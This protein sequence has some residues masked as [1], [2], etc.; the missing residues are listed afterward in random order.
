MPY[1][2]LDHTRQVV[3]HIAT[4]GNFLNLPATFMEPVIIAGWFHDIGFLK[5]YKQHEKFS[6]CLASR[7]LFSKGFS[8]SKIK[9]IEE[10]I[11][12]TRMPQQPQNLESKILC[13]ADIFHLGTSDFFE[14]NQLLREEWKI[15]FN[16]HYSE[17]D[18]L[19]MNISFLESQRFST[20]F[21]R[22]I[23][24][25]GKSQNIAQLKDKLLIL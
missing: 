20:S 8:F 5:S 17:E 21:G 14:R 9:K 6:I 19:A 7:F 3:E 18:W 15:I 13:D 4:I 10:C 22:E 24:E 12:A 23:L 11:A 2:N 1:H 16:H 25:K